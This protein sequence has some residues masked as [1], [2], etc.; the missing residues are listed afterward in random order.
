MTKKQKR[1]DELMTIFSGKTF[2]NSTD[3]HYFIRAMLVE[4]HHDGVLEGL[5]RA[6]KLINKNLTRGEQ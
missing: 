5:E 2:T 6:S 4:A 1:I 3:A